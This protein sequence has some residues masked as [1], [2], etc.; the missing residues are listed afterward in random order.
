MSEE[1]NPLTHWGRVKHICVSDLTNI[2]SDNSLLPGRHQAI[3]WTNAGN[4]V[5]WSPKNKLQW[6][7]KRN[8]NIFFQEN[9]FE[10]IDRLEKGGHFVSTSMC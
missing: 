3:I 2:G 9:P 8:S 10:N 7:F 5:N 4:I 1:F 6:N